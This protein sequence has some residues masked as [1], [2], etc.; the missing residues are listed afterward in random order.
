MCSS[1]LDAVLELV[2]RR[3]YRDIQRAKAQEDTHEGEEA[4]ASQRTPLR[5][6]GLIFHWF[7]TMWGTLLRLQTLYP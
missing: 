6:M 2:R 5:S 7:T 1:D 4:P 3:A